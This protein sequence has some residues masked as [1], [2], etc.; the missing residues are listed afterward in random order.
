MPRPQRAT[1][2][3]FTSAMWKTLASLNDEK[4]NSTENESNNQLPARSYQVVCKCKT[5]RSLLVLTPL[6]GIEVHV[7]LLASHNANV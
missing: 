1:Q 5:L 3:H 2:R 6:T 4:R 7:E